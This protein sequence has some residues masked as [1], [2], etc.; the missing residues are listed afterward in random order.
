MLNPRSHSIDAAVLMGLNKFV[1]EFRGLVDE[2]VLMAVVVVVVVVD[3]FLLSRLFVDFRVT[4]SFKS[5][6]DLRRFFSRC[7]RLLESLTFSK[8]ANMPWFGLH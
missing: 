3:D 5:K 7:S 2:A 1:Y 8:G 4:S 6:E